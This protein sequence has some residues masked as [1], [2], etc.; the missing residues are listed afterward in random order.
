MKSGVF[1]TLFQRPSL[2]DALAYVS[3][4]KIRMVE[5]ATG[6]YVGNHHVKPAI[7]QPV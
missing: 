6:G 7:G 5:I 2:E 1:L 4:G 3:N